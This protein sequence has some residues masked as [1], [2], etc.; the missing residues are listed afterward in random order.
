MVLFQNAKWI[1]A[2]TRVSED[3]YTE[4]TDTLRKS[5][6]QTT[7][8]IS[9]VSDYTVW[10]NGRYVASNQYGD[11]EHYKIYD[12]IDI[13][14]YLSEENNRLDVTLYYCG[15][16]TQRHS[17]ASAGL[18]YE[19]WQEEHCVC[20]SG[21]HTLSRKSPTY[22]S[23]LC[24]LC[25]PQLGYTFAYDATAECDGGYAPSR[26]V[27]KQTCLLPRPLPKQRVCER[28]EV[29][30]ITKTDR[31][32][33]LVDLGKELV[34]LAALEFT[35]NTAQVLRIAYG[36]SLSG[37]HVRAEIHNRHFFFEYKA[38]Q[39]K[40]AFTDYML[41]LCCRYLEVFAQDPIE[42]QYVGI[43][44]QVY[45]VEEIAHALPTKTEQRIYDASVN[46]LR[47]CMM[48]HYVDTPWREQCLYAFDSRNQMLSGY[49]AFKH[50]NRDY[51]RA[52]LAL[53]S[54][55]HREDGLLSIC[56]PCAT[57][58]AIPSFSLYYVIAM[59]EYARHTG[60]FTLAVK[61]CSK[62][63][64][65]LDEFIKRKSKDGLICNFS[66][67]SMWN[68]YDWSPHLDGADR[69]GGVPDLIINTLTVLALD[70]CEAL[71]SMAGIPFRYAGEAE[72]LRS[73]ARAHF[74]DPCG[75]YSLHRSDGIFTALGN[76]LAVLS[77]VASDVEHQRICEE[78]LGGKLTR[79]SLS[80]SVWIYD[81]LIQT[82]AERYRDLIR[83]DILQKYGDMSKSGTVWE[84]E[85]G[86]EDFDGAGSLCHGWSAIPV[87]V[88]ERLGL[89][90]P[91]EQK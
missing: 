20:H 84:T 57:D 26:I 46:T 59:H 60:D 71:F 13:G 23:G 78:L 69:S 36:E 44:P 10:I 38:K 15:A 86:A 74:S 52:S 14:A 67:A 79:P 6:L 91:N 63:E 45:D 48:E 32:S 21:A 81:A 75:L 72:T 37:E 8:Y 65:V 29:K 80:M 55:D 87:Y 88:Y 50:G 11:F 42:I 47:L 34:G 82:G 2:D 83:A 89:F 40:N 49:V 62:I 73:S 19:I 85:R 12:A 39:G 31:G 27:D 18:I 17:R 22:Q 90:L 56:A 4:Y 41:R 54:E 30:S 24:R 70:A 43:L 16:P 68:F 76:A 25:S 5:D 33:Y 51:A 1:I 66:G 7:L 9:A 61:Y 3:L 53:L 28:A 77:G 35:S 58:L 64:G